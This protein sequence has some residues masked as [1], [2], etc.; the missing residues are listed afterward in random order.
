MTAWT[1]KFGGHVVPW[2]CCNGNGSSGPVT[3]KAEPTHFFTRRNPMKSMTFSKLTDFLRLWSKN[4]WEFAKSVSTKDIN[5]IGKLYYIL[6]WRSAF[7]VTT[8]LVPVSQK[9]GGGTK[10]SN[11]NVVLKTQY[12]TNCMLVDIV[13][14]KVVLIALRIDDVNVHVC[15]HLPFSF[16]LQQ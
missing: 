13:A 14:R 10:R 16:A 12:S 2:P 5:Y 9:H 11:F 8:L 6:K 1:W 7:D 4:R 3:S 15:P